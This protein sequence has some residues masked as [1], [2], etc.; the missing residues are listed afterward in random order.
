MCALLAHRRASGFRAARWM[1]ALLLVLSVAAMPS[2]AE[3]PDGPAPAAPTFPAPGAWVPSSEA[4]GA[5]LVYL[6]C[7]ASGRVRYGLA[8]RVALL[9]V[10]G[11]FTVEG[12]TLALECAG[13]PP[14]R[15]QWTSKDASSLALRPLDGTD[16]TAQPYVRAAAPPGLIRAWADAEAKVELELR[17]DHTCRWR[18]P[19]PAQAEPVDRMGVW[20][21]ADLALL[22]G[23]SG[24][25]IHVL[26]GGSQGTFEAFRYELVGT[27]GLRLTPEAERSFLKEPRTL[28]ATPSAWTRFDASA[29]AG[30]S[31]DGEPPDGAWVAIR[32]GAPTGEVL[33]CDAGGLFTRGTETVA[34]GRWTR[35]GE[36]L[37]FAPVE[38]AEPKGP[39]SSPGATG[40]G[41]MG[42]DGTF[43]V[44]W[45]GDGAGPPTRYERARRPASLVGRW[46]VEGD[47]RSRARFE[48]GADGALT[49]DDGDA[50]EDGTPRPAL[51]GAWH[52][53]GDTLVLAV[54]SGGQRRTTLFSLPFVQA[55]RL[56]C[57]A[58]G[59][60]LVFLLVRDAATPPPK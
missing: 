31:K 19:T 42:A 15:F 16:T 10:L 38:G 8:T 41:H 50:D 39:G 48:L 13:M 1:P 25:G 58:S 21:V 12:D 4:K 7:E 36:G 18:A 43:T 60:G 6:V 40:T 34:E 29:N 23:P 2:A 57:D 14:Q 17:A 52:A 47:E 9:A 22:G 59:M 27:D 28:R 56:L 37:R 45:T 35:A 51:H 46:R 24:P 30:P 26:A 33:G 3:P 32:R 53:W 20:F 49:W 5:D 55:D 54:V 11:T 44:A